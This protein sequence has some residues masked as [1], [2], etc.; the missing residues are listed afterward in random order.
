MTTGAAS[1]GDPLVSSPP[2]VATPPQNAASAADPVRGAEAARESLVF[3]NF[4]DKGFVA[5]R[6]GAAPVVLYFEADWCQPCKE[7][8]ATTFRDPAVIE[9][10]AGMEL[11][12]IDMTVSDRYVD[13]VRESF[14]VSGAPTLIVFAPG[15]QEAARRFGFI[16]AGELTEMLAKGRKSPAGS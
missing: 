12:R 10:A 14:Q 2:A 3:R 11:F 9:A 7:L 5:A 6:N 13:L 4:D 8:H 1:A 16:P 15:G